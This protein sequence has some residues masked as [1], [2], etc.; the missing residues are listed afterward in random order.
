MTRE[1]RRGERQWLFVEPPSCPC[2]EGPVPAGIGTM[3]ARGA[4]P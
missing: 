1:Q 4:L 3:R 2:G